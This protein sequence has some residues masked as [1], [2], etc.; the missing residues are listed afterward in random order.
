MC[1]SWIFFVLFLLCWYQFS[2]DYYFISALQFISPNSEAYPCLP[3][4]KEVS[5]FPMWKIL[6]RI[7]QIEGP[8]DQVSKVF[9][10]WCYWFWAWIN[11]TCKL[12]CSGQ[13]CLWMFGVASIRSIHSLQTELVIFLSKKPF[14]LK[15]YGH[16]IFRSY[17]INCIISNHRVLSM[18]IFQ[19][20]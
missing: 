14:I 8:Y 13:N 11:L 3:F 18:Q 7:W 17:F 19:C 20:F 16:Y 6:H 15:E 12:L 10:N 1:F 5:V 9:F 2:V 4:G